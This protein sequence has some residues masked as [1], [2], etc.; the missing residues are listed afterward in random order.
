M[1]NVQSTQQ[2]TPVNFFEME[3]VEKHL[4]FPDVFSQGEVGTIQRRK[5]RHPD[6]LP[7]NPDYV[8]DE[9]TVRRALAWWYSLS[10]DQALG[11]HGETG[12][13]KTELLLYIADR[14][15]EPVYL[16]KVH[17]ALMP[18][19]LEGSK[20]LV[21][22]EKGVVT[23]NS[24]GLAAKAYA[25]GGL[26]ILDEVDKS[27]AP[28]GCALHGLVEGKPWPIEQFG[29]VLNK[30][31][32]CRVSGTANTTGE[33]GHERYHTSNRMDQALR[34]RFGWLETHFPQPARE[35]Q[36]LAKKFPKLPNKMLKACVSLAN[37]MRDAVLGPA[38]SDGKRSG[39]VQDPINAVFSTRTLVRW[40]N[41]TM[42]FGPKATWRE[43]LNW[44]FDGSV[45]SE[46][47]AAVKAIIQRELDTT[48]DE[49]V[50]EVC[51]FYAG[52]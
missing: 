2:A 39:D 37:A 52:K 46:S 50:A 48:I 14:L 10:K 36:I 4:L 11:L 22:G 20:E 45:D 43:S 32:F 26:I 24:L 41:T 49:P 21:N 40:C 44:A 33:G 27:N 34:S 51:K 29:L 38:D 47:R 7:S 8:P 16:I 42:A 6:C 23:K 13:G 18:E 9:T 35:M 17:P 30:H 1:S 12:T 3:A 19:D 15:N 28:L 25:M 31:P 5:N